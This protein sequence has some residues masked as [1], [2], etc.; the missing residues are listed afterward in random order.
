[1]R[2]TSGAISSTFCPGAS[3]IDTFAIASTG[4]TVFWRTGEPVWIPFTSSAGSAN[5]RR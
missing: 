5:V 1:M 4:S 3:L 2:S